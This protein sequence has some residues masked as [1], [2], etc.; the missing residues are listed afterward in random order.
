M[1]LEAQKTEARRAAFA[2]RK[3]AHAA[4]S[5]ASASVLSDVLAGYRG[6]PVA[7]FMPIGTEID[8]SPALAEASAHGPVGL[9]V[10]QAAGA[11]L[12]FALYTPGMQMVEGAFKALIPAERTWMVPEIVIV[13]LVAWDAQGGRLGYGGGFYDRTLE[14]LRARRPTI[15]VGFAFDA[16]EMPE[17]PIEDTDQKLDF[18][19]TESGVRA[20]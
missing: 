4:Q 18:I 12:R 2:R 6:A 8:P 20:F 10:I 13:P 15:A 7:G 17:G 16:Q 14:G 1:S 3:Q 9:P 5:G 19:V 11:P